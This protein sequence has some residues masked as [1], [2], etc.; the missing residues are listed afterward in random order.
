VIPEG[1]S[2]G[3]EYAR[4]GG[5]RSIRRPPGEKVRLEEDPLPRADET[6]SPAKELQPALHRLAYLVRVVAF[7]AHHGDRTRGSIVPLHSGF[8]LFP[9]HR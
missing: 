5:N 6:I 8:P 7:T 9:I 2:H 4:M 1:L 3:A